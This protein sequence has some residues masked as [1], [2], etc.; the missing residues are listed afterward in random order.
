MAIGSITEL[1]PYVRII[2][3]ILGCLVTMVT[4][5]I[6]TGKWIEQLRT[7]RKSSR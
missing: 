7:W 3:A 2:A 5:F 4:L 6:Q 1:D